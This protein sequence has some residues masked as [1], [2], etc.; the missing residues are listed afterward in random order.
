MKLGA[1]GLLAAS[2]AG[3]ALS[4]AM[5]GQGAWAWVRAFCEAATVGALADWFAV[6]A[7]FKRPLGLPIPHTAIIPGNKAR[8]ADNL[9]IFV[10]DHFLAPEALLARLQVFDPA[11]RLGAWLSEPAQARAAAAMARTWMSQALDLLDDRAVRDALQ[12]FVV[13]RL[14][15][16]DAGAT[17]GEVLGLLTR[18]GRHH[19]LLDEALRR[20]GDYLDGEGVKERVSDL[21][22]K[23]A[24]KEWPKIV[25]AVNLVKPVDRIA[26]SL[27]DRLARALLDEL[28]EILSR[29]DHPLRRDYEAWVGD[30][31]ARLRDDAQLREQIDQIKARL[32]DHPSVQEYVQDLW[33]EIRAALRRNLGSEDSPLIRHLERSLSRLG[34]QLA[35]DP[36]LRA[37]INE[38]VMSGASSLAGRLSTGVTEHIAQTVKGWDERHLVRELELS[39][40]PDLQ[41]IRYNGTL[42]GGLIGVALHALVIAFGG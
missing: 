27:A 19:Q 37:A 13:A 17:A 21:M 31:M 23:Y 29:P 22:V 20:L 36:A 26:D 24:R 6:V 14:R 8:L 34:R 41:Y 15:A 12:S 2:L 4:H 7:L 11:A 16:W 42:V 35:A 38:H 5:G 25:G 28:H 3:V 1:L 39:V 10:R 32:I 18:D 40:G 9:A 33:T 30:Y